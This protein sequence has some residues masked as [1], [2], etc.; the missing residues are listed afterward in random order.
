MIVLKDLKFGM[1]VTSRLSWDEIRKQTQE[2]ERL[3]FHS[4]W[5]ADHLVLRGPRLEG[6]TLISALAP[7]TESIRLGSLVLSNSFRNPALL[8]KMGA[9]LDVISGGRLELG[10][11]AGWHESEYRAYGYEFPDAR[12]RIRQLEE[13]VKIIQMMWTEEHPTYEGEYFSISDAQCEPRP[14]QK[15]YPPITIGGGGEKFLL[16]VVAQYADRCN[17]GGSPETCQR[18]LQVLKGHCTSVG[19][20]Y[21]EIERSMF[22]YIHVGDEGSLKENMRKIYDI[23]P[24]SEPFERWYREN[25]QAMIAGT[26]DEC[27]ERIREFE[28]LGFTLLILRFYQMPSIEMIKQLHDQIIE[29]I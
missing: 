25:R 21:D 3:G 24:I 27:V 7:I 22:S 29:C 5:F 26:A 19:R 6:W 20:D 9:T 18:K 17:L 15:P 12:T 16:R 8:A 2:C 14:V 13:G 4:M 11:G 28:R 23:S 10:I 1:F